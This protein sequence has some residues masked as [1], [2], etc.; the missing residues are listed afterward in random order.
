MKILRYML[1]LS[2]LLSVALTASAQIDRHDVRA[3]NRKFRKDNWKEADIS[4]RK[5]LVKDSTSVAANYNLANT[6]YRQENYEEA[7]K[8]MKKIGDNASASANAA[9]YWYNTGD[10]AIAKKDWQGA[11]NAFKEALLKNP[12]DM[13]AKENYIYA[14]KMLENQQKNGGGKGDGQ[15][16]Q[17]QNNQDQN[18]QNQDQNKNGQ[19]QNK[20]QN[21]DQNNDGQNKDQDQ[22]RNQ[23]QN[24]G[25]GNGNQQPPQGQEGKI[26][27]QQA[28]QMLRAIQA[29][30]K[31]TQD[32][33]NK[34]KADAL[35][36]RQKEKN[37]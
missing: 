3:G 36:S 6:L 21:N 20:D 24:N 7:E 22:N 32:K 2:M 11:V 27:P 16:N 10:I 4:Y 17:D 9:D 23:N 5:A 18:N 37:W 19:D 33:V 30:E 13:D 29:K 14:K 8:L 1:V 15:D 31:E 35:K 34:E 28:Q 25:Q 12:S 26:S